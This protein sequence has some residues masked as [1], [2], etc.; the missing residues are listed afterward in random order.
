MRRWWG[1]GIN[2]RNFSHCSLDFLVDQSPVTL[3]RGSDIAV[4]KEL[5]TFLLF[6]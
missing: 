6:G 4:T 5:E 2:T 3:L 1:C